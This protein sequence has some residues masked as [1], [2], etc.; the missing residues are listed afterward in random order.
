M[1][2]V[3]I[4]ADYL[5]KM[6]PGVLAALA[7]YGCLYPRRCRRLQ[8]AGLISLRRREI[9]LVLFWMFCGGMVMLTL[10]PREFDLI[11]ALRWGWAGPFFRLGS[12]NLIP[13]QTVR[14]NGMLLYILLGNILMFLPFGFFPALV[15]RGSAWKR[16]L[17]TGFCVTGFI[18]CWQLLAGRAFDIDDLWLNTLGAMAGFWLLRLLER[19]APAQ[20]EKFRVRPI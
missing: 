3:W 12:V 17:L 2:Y 13:F 9:A 6:L 1:R 16:A 14:L 5:R 7:V 8:A 18:E 11:A 10:T 19:L 4:T 20:V 15:W